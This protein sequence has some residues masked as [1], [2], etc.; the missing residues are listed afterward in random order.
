MSKTLKPIGNPNLIPV[1]T[2]SPTGNS[3]LAT[4]LLNVTEDPPTQPSVQKKNA[5]K[6][7]KRIRYEDDEE[8]ETSKHYTKK[9]RYVPNQWR[10]SLPH[11]DL[12]GFDNFRDLH[13]YLISKN[14][15]HNGD[16]LRRDYSKLHTQ[17]TLKLPEDIT[18][19]N[20]LRVGPGIDTI[21]DGTGN[22]DPVVVLNRNKEQ[23]KKYGIR[24]LNK[25]NDRNMFLRR[26]L[27]I[28][29]AKIEQPIYQFVEMYTAACANG[30]RVEDYL[31][32]FPE[33]IETLSRKEPRLYDKQTYG[34]EDFI[35]EL[36]FVLG[37]SAGVAD[38]NFR[39]VIKILNSFIKNL[40]NEDYNKVPTLSR[41]RSNS[42]RGEDT[43]AF[44]TSAKTKLKT[45]TKTKG[46][47][48]GSS[49]SPSVEFRSPSSDQVRSPSV[50]KGFKR[51]DPEDDDDS[52]AESSEDLTYDERQEKFVTGLKKKEFREWQTIFEN[53]FRE[54]KTATLLKP[55]KDGLHPLSLLILKPDIRGLM[56][57]AREELNV[58]IRQKYSL[59]QYIF[60]TDCASF[61]AKFMVQCRVGQSLLSGGSFN[62]F[63]NSN[64]AYRG[65]GGAPY[66]S[67]VN[68]YS[69]HPSRYILAEISKERESAI[70]F[71]KNVFPA[72][73]YDQN[74]D[75]LPVAHTKD[76]NGGF[77]E[78]PL[79]FTESQPTTILP[80]RFQSIL[81]NDNLDPNAPQ[82]LVF[83][84]ASNFER[85]S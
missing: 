50:K 77:I 72:G 1:R 46:P 53:I 38:P 20:T 43:E 48:E 54:D 39:Q 29:L 30:S 12:P 11:V 33:D 25:G 79:V 5:F 69:R 15:Y 47:E 82:P 19:E 49:D 58:Q 35:K 37:N 10:D 70:N 74:V 62:D 27:L 73:P 7:K 64:G 67:I 84:Y 6:I 31:W 16:S 56:K 26:Q 61:F 52:D 17:K 28:H 2:D 66:A 65:S 83:R 68:N 14:V 22:L 23:E 32:V 63:G 18:P 60:S 45:T 24:F 4:A 13:K 71:F 76:A 34:P 42:P 57:L 78:R 41:E 3:S 80:T 59:A 55:N 21:D 51:R 40:S 85:R 36:L 9:S 44:S 81:G 75:P 8:E